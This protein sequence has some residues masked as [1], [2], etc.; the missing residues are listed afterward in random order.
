M[1]DQRLQIYQAFRYQ[2]DRFWI[3][4]VVAELEPDVDLA[5]RGVHEWNGLE[6]LSHANDEHSTAKARGLVRMS[7]M[8]IPISLLPGR[9]T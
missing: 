4:L 8:L 7:A 2:R 1:R 6:V 9:L 5:E 3:R